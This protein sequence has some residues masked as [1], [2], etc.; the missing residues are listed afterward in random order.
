MSCCGGKRRALRTRMSLPLANQPRPLLALKNSTLLTYLGDS[1]IVVR[2]EHTGH[3]YLF[4]PHG[5]ALTV[6]D[7]DM[8]RLIATGWFRKA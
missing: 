3:T 1:S 5:D 7:R 8:P 2:G 4:G 6:D